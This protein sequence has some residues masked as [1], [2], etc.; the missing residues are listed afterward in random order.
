MGYEV[1]AGLGVK[2]A[3]PTRNVIVMVGDGSWL[4][5]SSELVTAISEG[6]RLTVVLVV[7][8]GFASIGNL[9]ESVGVERLGTRYRYRTESGLDGARLPVDFAANAASL[10]ALALRASTAR[11]WRVRS[12]EH[13]QPKRQ[14]SSSSRA[15]RLCRLPTQLHGG[16][17]RSLSS[18]PVLRR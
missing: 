8:H 17:C 1:A 3:D 13:E 5:I 15:T 12:R 6:I 4:M 16:T 14:R 7:N 10:G 18:P 11:N 2:M 9:S